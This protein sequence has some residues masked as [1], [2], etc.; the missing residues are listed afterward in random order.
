M[1]VLLNDIVCC[2]CACVL[3]KVFFC[4]VVFDV[5][6]LCLLV[7]VCCVCVC[8]VY[9]CLCGLF[10]IECVMLYGLFFGGGVFFFWSCVLFCVIL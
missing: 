10:V 1:C 4:D 7:C 3:F 6:W 2:V 5:V 9:M 8:V